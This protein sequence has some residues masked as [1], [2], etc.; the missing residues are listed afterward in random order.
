MKNLLD[1]RYA[2]TVGKF[3]V[4]VKVEE[5]LLLLFELKSIRKS[6]KLMNSL[7]EE[8]VHGMLN[9]R[10]YQI[11]ASNNKQKIPTQCAKYV[12]IA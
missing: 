6:K 9:K 1:I 7:E 10:I 12:I 2:V 5:I 4:I 11:V 8:N 3:S